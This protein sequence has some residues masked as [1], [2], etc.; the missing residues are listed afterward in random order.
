VVLSWSEFVG[1]LVVELSN[2]K[3]NLLVVFHID[4]DLVVVVDG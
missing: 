4:F 1:V 2:T 3:K